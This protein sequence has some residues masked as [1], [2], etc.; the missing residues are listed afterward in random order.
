MNGFLYTDGST[1]VIEQICT[2]R[3]LERSISQYRQWKLTIDS[4]HSHNNE[5]AVKLRVF[6]LSEYLPR[7]DFQEI[8]I[9]GT[10]ENGPGHSAKYRGG[11]K[12]T[13]I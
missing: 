13:R 6:A 12:G 1:D 4:I 10:T 8:R 2:T 3:K 9:R 11:S 5:T 7:E